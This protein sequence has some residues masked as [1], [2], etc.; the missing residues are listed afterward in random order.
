MLRENLKILAKQ[1]KRNETKEKEMKTEEKFKSS[2]PMKNESNMKDED[3][4]KRNHQL[5]GSQLFVS[6][7]LTRLNL[8]LA[9][10]LAW[11]W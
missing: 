10:A 7:V 11:A 5:L 3:D 6:F 8:A 4:K 2:A 9:L 1:S